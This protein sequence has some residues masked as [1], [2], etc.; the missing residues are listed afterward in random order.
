MKKWTRQATIK[1]GTMKKIVIGA[2]VA[3]TPAMTK[4]KKLSGNGVIDEKRKKRG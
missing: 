3:K 2:A 4:T 1:P